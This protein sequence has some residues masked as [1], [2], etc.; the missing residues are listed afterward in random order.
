MLAAAIL[1]EACAAHI[2]KLQA[3]PEAL[4]IIEKY[5]NKLQL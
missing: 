1:L 4:Q 5:H 3:L 2:K